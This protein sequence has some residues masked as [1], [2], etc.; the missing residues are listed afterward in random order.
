[1][2]G[3]GGN[4]GHDFAACLGAPYLFR[5]RRGEIVSWDQPFF[6][7]I[8]LPWRGISI[9]HS[10]TM[11]PQ[12]QND[13]GSFILGRRANAR[14]GSMEQ[15]AMSGRE[16]QADANLLSAIAMMIGGALGAGLPMALV[17]IWLCA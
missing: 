10:L 14:G 5:W 17:I 1:M 13:L 7:P 8:R 16:M 3:V 4:L 9:N 2:S 6:D 12:A 11:C 15:T